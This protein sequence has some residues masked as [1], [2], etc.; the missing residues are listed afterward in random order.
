M[1]VG[2]KN[3]DCQVEIGWINIQNLIKSKA[4]EKGDGSVLHIRG[5]PEQKLPID[6][7]ADELTVF[8]KSQMLIR[9]IGFVA[10]LQWKKMILIIW[11]Y[12]TR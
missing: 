8:K 9:S 7:K 4:G 1:K 10:V 6:G 2:V 5:A 3:A 11:I 12:S